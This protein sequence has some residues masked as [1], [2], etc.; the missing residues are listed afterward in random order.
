MLYLTLVQ[1]DCTEFLERIV[2]HKEQTGYAKSG[3]FYVSP[4]GHLYLTL[5]TASDNP[6]QVELTINDTAG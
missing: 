4:D 6:V 2:K 3:S 1:Q 5:D